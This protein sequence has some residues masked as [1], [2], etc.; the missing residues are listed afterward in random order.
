[1]SLPNNFR[2]DL[3]AFVHSYPYTN[4]H[5]V[6]LDFLIKQLEAFRDF[7]NNLGLDEMKA[8]IEQIQGQIAEMIPEIEKIPGMETAVEALLGALT[9]LSE[10]VDENTNRIGELSDA[11]DVINDTIN[12]LDT[13]KQDIENQINTINSTDASQN[14]RLDALEEATIGSL[15]V[16]A[17]NYFFQDLRFPVMRK[18]VTFHKVSDDSELTEAELMTTDYSIGLWYSTQSNP[19]VGNYYWGDTGLTAQRQNIPLFRTQGTAAYMKIHN[20][21]PYGYVQTDPR[22]VVLNC[23]HWQS[24][25]GIDWLKTTAYTVNQ[26]FSG[27]QPSG[28]VGPFVDIKF[29]VNQKDACIDLIMYNGRNNVYVGADKRLLYVVISDIVYNNVNDFRKSL[30][31]TEP[32]FMREIGELSAQITELSGMADNF[33]R[34]SI[35]APY[36]FY[37][38]DSSGA[39]SYT[40][41]NRSTMR[42]VNVGSNESS[43]VDSDDGNTYYPANGIKKYCE[44]DLNISY[45]SPSAALDISKDII[46][47][48]QLY[49]VVSS[50][51][52]TS[53]PSHTAMVLDVALED[54]YTGTA[55]L[56]NNDKINITIYDPSGSRTGTYNKK[57]RITGHLVYPI[58]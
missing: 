44:L 31:N 9:D 13:W 56:D 35:Q 43:F 29:V 15:T 37:N 57:I 41:T 45:S 17:G 36:I 42:T 21:M 38:P 3:N 51:G 34:S 47:G 14:T 6:V 48:S 28:N 2:D 25:T 22:N 52:S 19:N 50:S 12:G 30:M 46:A 54:G 16:N 53:I 40:M 26:M 11:V 33:K 39:I 23:Y 20:V 49:K 7:L 1:M 5:E 58:S 55:I 27:Q 24:Q 32:M 4:Y 18:N 10:L 8:A